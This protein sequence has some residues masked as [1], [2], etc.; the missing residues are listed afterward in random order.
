MSKIME[1]EEKDDLNKMNRLIKKILSVI[2][3]DG[4]L[5]I[6]FKLEPIS[7]DEYYLSLKY[8]VPDDSPA[9][10]RKTVDNYIYQWTDPIHKTIQDYLGISVYIK[11]QGISSK[12]FSHL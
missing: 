4:V 1:M 12:S 7:D 8:I 6:K 11:N 5:E 10:N 9:L 3:P 2:K